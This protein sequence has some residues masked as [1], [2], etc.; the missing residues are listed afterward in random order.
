MF[1]EVSVKHTLTLRDDHVFSDTRMNVAWKESIFHFPSLTQHW[2]S[3]PALGLQNNPQ[4]FLLWFS[5]TGQA[6]VLVPWLCFL[7]GNI[8]VFTVRME[9]WQ[10][11]Q[12]ALHWRKASA[13]AQQLKGR[14]DSVTLVWPLSVPFCFSWGMLTLCCSNSFAWGGFWCVACFIFRIS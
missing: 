4:T 8:C 2:V 5:F 9:C 12:N 11:K 13:A 6:P 3:Q 1:R 7:R 14:E 10:I